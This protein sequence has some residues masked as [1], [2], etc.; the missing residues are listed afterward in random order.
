VKEQDTPDKVNVLQTSKRS[1]GDCHVEYV[2]IKTS[3]I[4]IYYV[5]FG[6]FIGLFIE[7]L[8]HSFYGHH[9]SE[10]KE[11]RRSSRNKNP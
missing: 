9:N 10:E 1:H 4:Y 7:I 2:H 5:Y 6:T 8:F 3:A 11:K